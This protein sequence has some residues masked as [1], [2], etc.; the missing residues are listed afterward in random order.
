M[1]KQKEGVYERVLECAE[2][3]FLKKGFKDASLREIAKEAGTSTGSIY[4]RFRDKEGLFRELAEPVLEELKELFTAIQ[5][6]FD[7]LEEDCKESSMRSYSEN[8][9]EKVLDYIYD[10]M[11]AFKL[12]LDASYGTRFQNFLDELV[13]IEVRYTFRYMKAI[14]CRTLEEGK[15]SGEFIHIAATGYFSAMFEVVRHNMDRDQAERYIDMLQ[16]YHQ[17]G[18]DTI[19]YPEKYEHGKDDLTDPI[20]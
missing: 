14:G 19:F 10:H 7:Q 17:A 6:R 4:T 2:K 13:E 12:L 3:E 1:A 15:T 18:F 20:S 9:M 11:D 8:G 16:K 5:E